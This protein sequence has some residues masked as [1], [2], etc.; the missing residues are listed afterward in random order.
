M[1]SDIPLTVGTQQYLCHIRIPNFTEPN[2]GLPKRMVVKPPPKLRYWSPKPTQPRQPKMFWFLSPPG[3]QKLEKF[4][5]QNKNPSRSC[6]IL[7]KIQH[8]RSSCV[9]CFFEN[10]PQKSF[11]YC[12]PVWK[13]SVCVYIFKLSEHWKVNA[14]HVNARLILK[15]VLKLVNFHF[16]ASF[17]VH[18]CP[19]KPWFALSTRFP[20]LLNISLG[21]HGSVFGDPDFSLNP[22]C[23]HRFLFFGEGG[24]MEENPHTP[25]LF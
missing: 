11:T 9:P 21:Q 6:W 3:S 16:P 25:H 20:N 23:Q 5:Q 12:L 2:R 10:L 8:Q 4:W 1:I 7:L 14:V 13:M 15:M 17:L 22:A 19:D 18:R 24:Q